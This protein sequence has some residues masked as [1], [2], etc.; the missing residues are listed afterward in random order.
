[1]TPTLVN[2]IAVLIGSTLGLLLHKHISDRFRAILFQA[3]G[4]ATI[5]IGLK[6]A[7]RTQ[8]IP[9]LALSMILGGLLGE[10]IN[11]EERLKS[12]GGSLKTMMRQEGDS[13]FIDS[14]VFASILFCAG[15]MTIVGCFRAGVEGDGD[16]LY[17]KSLLDGHAAI[18]LAG[19]MGAGVLASSFT[20]L[21]FQ[22][23]LTVLFMTLGGL[24]DYIITEAAAVGGLLIVAISINMM[25]LGRVRVG[26]L[27]PGMFLVGFLVWLKHLYF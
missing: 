22:G 10:W 14:F 4:L 9:M 2:T 17:T 26:N 24:P 3:I 11:I 6:D 27:L 19:T 21:M 25:E 15:A 20:I 16:L 23:G 12:L 5:A 1:M 7:L 13:G 18:F 8:E